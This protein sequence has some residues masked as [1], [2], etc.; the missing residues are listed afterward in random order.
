MIANLHLLAISMYFC[1]RS[2]LD[3]FSF[4]DRQMAALRVRS[5]FYSSWIVSGLII[6]G[7]NQRG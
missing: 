6:W 4:S 3:L 2:G 1:F 5:F 7:R